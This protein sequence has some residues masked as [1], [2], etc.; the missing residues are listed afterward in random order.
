MQVHLRLPAQQVA[1]FGYAIGD[2]PIPISQQIEQLDASSCQTQ[3]QLADGRQ[4]IDRAGGHS[5]PAVSSGQLPVAAQELA[6]DGRG[7]G[8]AVECLTVTGDVGSGKLW[9]CTR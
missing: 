2:G 6:P 7:V 4:G 8:G 1:G 3:R 5:Q 9:A